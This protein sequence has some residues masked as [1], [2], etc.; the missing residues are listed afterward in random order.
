MTAERSGTSADNNSRP[1]SKRDPMDLFE[2]LSTI[3]EAIATHGL[4]PPVPTPDRLGLS[5]FT[6]LVAVF[7]PRQL[8]GNHA[9]DEDHLKTL[10]GAIG[11]P[12]KPN[13]LDP[14]RVWWGGDR[15]YVVDGH[16]RR[17]AY[18]RAGVQRGIPV[19]RF[20]GTLEDAMAYTAE[21]NSKDRLPMTKADKLNR[22]WFLNVLT[23]KSKA[24]IRRAC[25]VSTG[26]INNMRNVRKRLLDQGSSFEELAGM[27]WRDAQDQL[28]GREPKQFDPDDAVRKQANEWRDRISRTFGNK[29]AAFSEAFALALLLSNSSLPKL[30]MTTNSWDD[31]F[32]EVL[33][34]LAD[35]R[36][37]ARELLSIIDEDEDY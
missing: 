24:E 2:A 25:S 33:G 36:E 10:E 13:Y 31:D 22:A 19:N 3:R 4:E 29:P 12:K 20:E 17:V 37:D 28:Y 7:Q 26:T 6:S 8:N 1:L 5:E 32:K 9:K 14:I 15:Y 16:H 11:D 23:S 27:T 18:Q 35:Q 34:E 21:A 30:L